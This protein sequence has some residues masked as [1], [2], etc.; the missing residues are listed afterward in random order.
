MFEGEFEVLFVDFDLLL[1]KV[2]KIE[3]GK[4]KV[5]CLKL[6]RKVVLNKRKNLFIDDE[7]VCVDDEVVCV[8]ESGE[9]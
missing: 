8:D 7:V 4:V 9:W 5:D 2:F 3:E 6:W 1:R